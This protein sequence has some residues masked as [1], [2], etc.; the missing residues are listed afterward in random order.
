[1]LAIG[2]QGF[3]VRRAAQGDR[4]PHAIDRLPHTIDPLPHAMRSIATFYL[5]ICQT[6][7]DSRSMAWYSLHR[8]VIG[9]HIQSIARH[10]RLQPVEHQNV[11]QSTIVR[12]T[13]AILRRQ[14]QG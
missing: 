7:L 5:F 10:T 14:R 13:I 11:T 8:D 3:M 1:M 9:R 4:V 12:Y 2:M 6:R